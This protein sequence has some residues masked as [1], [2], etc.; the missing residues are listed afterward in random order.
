MSGYPGDKGQPWSIISHLLYKNIFLEAYDNPSTA[1]ELALE[2]GIALPYMEEELEFLVGEELLK[3]SGQKYE[4]A[5]PIVSQEEQLNRH[6]KLLDIATRVTPLIVFYIDSF[7]KAC[8]RSGI[9]WFG[10]WQNY[11]HA[12]WTLLMRTVDELTIDA[13]S[14]LPEIDFPLR[15]DNGKWQITGYEHINF[16]V[17][18]FV[19]EHGFMDSENKFEQHDLDWG[20]Y[21]FRQF[22][23]NQCTPEHLTYQEVLTIRKIA[24]GMEEECDQ[25]ILDK[26]TAYGYLRKNETGYMPTI[27]VFAKARSQ[28]EGLFAKVDLEQVVR[29]REQSVQIFQELHDVTNSVD[30]SI[31][32]YILEQALKGG[33]VKYNEDTPKI[34][35]S[36]L[37]L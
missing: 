33:W 5:F 7:Q 15:P 19:G 17:P 8:V 12:K 20:Q 3:K 29:L 34:I 14:D 18:L 1:D 4:T 2:I 37:C 21:K 28:I 27:C 32:G 25:I 30:F 22:E 26:V 16:D 6:R 24:L 13:L 10:S 31:R 11:D 36:Y 9:S 35:G 23:S